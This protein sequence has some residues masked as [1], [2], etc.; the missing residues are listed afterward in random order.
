[1]RGGW[2]HGQKR[3]SRASRARSRNARVHVKKSDFVSIACGPHANQAAEP[4]WLATDREPNGCVGETKQVRLCFAWGH[5]SRSDFISRSAKNEVRPELNPRVMVVVVVVVDDVDGDGDVDMAT[6]FDVRPPNLHLGRRPRANR[7]TRRPNAIARG[8]RV[9]SARQPS[10][11]LAR[12]V[13][14]SEDWLSHAVHPP[15]LAVRHG[16]GPVLHGRRVALQEHAV[17]EPEQRRVNSVR[18][19]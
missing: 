15:G 2:R 1:M 7:S 12:D 10:R 16:D 18:P 11:R 6:T 17:I 8:P 14:S 4:P 3:A 19:N 13:D 9:G 5:E